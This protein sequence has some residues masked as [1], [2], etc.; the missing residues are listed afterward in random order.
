MFV[1]ISFLSILMTSIYGSHSL[2]MDKVSL[3]RRPFLR[4]FRTVLTTLKIFK[5]TK[6]SV[7]NGKWLSKF[8]IK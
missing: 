5:K 6:S 8:I 2:F 7:S 3:Y 4:K 1:A